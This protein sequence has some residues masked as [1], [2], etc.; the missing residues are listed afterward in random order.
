MQE[1]CNI[2]LDQHIYLLNLY[3]TGKLTELMSKGIPNGKSDDNN[4]NLSVV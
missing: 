1:T 4:I 2:L 3:R